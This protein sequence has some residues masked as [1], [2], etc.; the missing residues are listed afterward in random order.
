VPAACCGVL[1]VKPTRGLIS[2][3]GVVPASRSFDCVSTFTRSC[4][5]AARVLG[6]TAQASWTPVPTRMRVGVPRK[7]EWFGDREGPGCFDAAVSKLSDSGV[8]LLTVD[9]ETFVDAGR[10]L[11]GSALAAE[12]AAAFGDFAAAHPDAMDPTVLAIVTAAADYEATD[13]FD[14]FERLDQYRNRALST[15]NE[16]DAIVVPTIARHPRVDEVLAD[17]F[18]P[19]AELGTYTSFVNLLDLCAVAAPI[20]HRA[21]G[22]PFGVSLVAPA[23]GDHLLLGLAADL[24]GERALPGPR[25]HRL[26]VVG[27]HLSG[28]PLNH[29]LLELGAR[30]VASTTTAPLYRLFDLGT[31]P[32]RPGMVREA[33]GG[34]AIEVEVWEF[35]PPG[36]GTFLPRVPAPLAI[37]SVELVDG[38]TV[39]G[40]LCESYALGSARDITSFGGWRAYRAADR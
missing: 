13:V 34:A 11:Y 12:R 36:L 38:T 8:E 9:L 39:L 7:L 28:Q 3:R 5:D 1:G 16:A 15:W 40:F 24:M 30:L 6:V 22:L 25:R 17:P 26:A 4:A 21:N 18:G 2:T 19:N 20:G 31:T 37:G 32:A 33:H 29:Q 27:A 35:D 23:Y 14:A 10:L